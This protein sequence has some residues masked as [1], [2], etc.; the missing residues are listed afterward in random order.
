MIK[1]TVGRKLIVSLLFG[2]VVLAAPPSRRAAAAFPDFEPSVGHTF[3]Q[4]RV[5]IYPDLNA[6]SASWQQ[7]NCQD[8]RGSCWNGR[9]EVAC[10]DNFRHDAGGAYS[11]LQRDGSGLPYYAPILRMRFTTNKEAPCCSG[12]AYQKTNIGTANL[13]STTAERSGQVFVVPEGVERITGFKATA[14]ARVGGNGVE[15][16]WRF[17]EF[18][19]RPAA[20]AQGAP[21]AEGR[22]WFPLHRDREGALVEGLD[23]AVTPGQVYYLEFAEPSDGQPKPVA[24]LPLV[25]NQDCDKF[26]ADKRCPSAPEESCRGPYSGGSAL[27]YD[28]DSGVTANHCRRPSLSG[29]YC[30]FDEEF[31]AD[32]ANLTIWGQPGSP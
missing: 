9:Q 8:A 16:T 29:N 6:A 21:L 30:V 17:Y 4:D 26:G 15:L 12:S 31:D 20:P 23:V 32:I 28:T 22:Q 13:G 24:Y 11:T 7:Q 10:Y 1:L 18:S 3:T 5:V 2:G 27:V 14:N 25:F 19:G